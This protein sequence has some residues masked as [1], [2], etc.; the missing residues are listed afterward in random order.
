MPERVCLTC[1]ALRQVSHKR[2]ERYLRLQESPDT[3]RKLLLL[4][5]RPVCRRDARRDSPLT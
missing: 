2:L 4:E 3:E 1:S 5:V